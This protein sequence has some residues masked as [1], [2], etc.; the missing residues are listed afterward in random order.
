MFESARRLR[1]LA[2]VALVLTVLQG[3]AWGQETLWKKAANLVCRAGELPRSVFLKRKRARPQPPPIFAWEKPSELDWALTIAQMYEANGEDEAAYMQYKWLCR[4]YPGDE[5][6]SDAAERLKAKLIEQQGPKWS[7]FGTL[8]TEIEELLDQMQQDREAA[9]GKL[10]RL[11]AKC[12]LPCAGAT[13]DDPIN[14][15][16]LF[17]FVYEPWNGFGEPTPQVDPEAGLTHSIVPKDRWFSW[18]PSPIKF[19]DIVP[20]YPT[21]RDILPD[22][23][24]SHLLSE[25]GVIEEPSRLLRLTQPQSAIYEGVEILF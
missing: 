5:R 12:G 11:I 20:F 15:D 2:A 19:D 24:C 13:G 16:P 1:M 17:L 10:A 4:R 7:F 25:F 14:D 3:R 8:L 9:A 21:L 18:W 23:E 22:S 6:F